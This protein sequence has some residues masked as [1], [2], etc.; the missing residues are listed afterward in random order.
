M[1]ANRKQNEWMNEWMN[2]VL[3][4]VEKKGRLKSWLNLQTLMES[5]W[6]KNNVFET[7]NKGKSNRIAKGRRTIIATTT[8]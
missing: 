4:A 7:K 3:I 1:T 8:A 6:L 5:I 2:W